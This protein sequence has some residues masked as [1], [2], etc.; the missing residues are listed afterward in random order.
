M[1]FLP[2]LPLS[3]PFGEPV[4]DAFT[5]GSGLRHYP[6]SNQCCQIQGGGAFGH[7]KHGLKF[8]IGD[9]PV[10]FEMGDSQALT[11]V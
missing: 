9:P 6:G 5:G 8:R 2:L 3:C 1:P 7:T 11:L 10:D 4:E